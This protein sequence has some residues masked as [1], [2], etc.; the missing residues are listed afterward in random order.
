HMELGGTPGAP[1][2]PIMIGDWFNNA[3][4]HELRRSSNFHN[5]EVNLL[6]FAVGGAARNFNMS[7]AGSLFSGRG[8]SN[9]GA[10]GGAG[11]GSCCAP[12]K[13]TTG[14][15]GLIAPTCGSCLNVSWLAG[16]RYFHFSDNLQYAAS[17]D[18]TMVDRSEDDL[19]YNVDTTN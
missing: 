3:R 19:Y 18:D 16:F 10:C 7:T 2:T 5:V 12:A 14:P 13:C 8:Q 11:C 4:A 15:C 17:L 9:C 6:G 1:G